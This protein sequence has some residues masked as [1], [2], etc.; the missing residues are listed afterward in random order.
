[1]RVLRKLKLNYLRAT[2]FLIS[3]VITTFSSTSH[4]NGEIQVIG[5]ILAEPC[6]LVNDDIIV[7]FGVLTNKDLFRYD[8]LEKF[9]VE[10][11]CEPGTQEAVQVQ[12]SSTNTSENNSILNLDTSSQASGV[13]IK[14][15]DDKG[16]YIVF[17][18]PQSSFMLNDGINNLN[19]TA[20]VSRKSDTLTL[21]DINLGAF[22]A[23]ASLIIEYK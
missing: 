9:S 18:E 10:L 22:T 6:T 21:N 8:R 1:M 11:D 12:F 20:H 7:D 13:G 2:L 17:N 4:A 19:F 5:L 3:S 23:T 16:N 14:I 15:E